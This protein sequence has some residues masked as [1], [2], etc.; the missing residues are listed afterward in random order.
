M[1]LVALPV[2][3]LAFRFLRHTR[4]GRS[5][6]LP[7]YDPPPDVTY[8]D[9][10]VIGY[11]HT[12]RGKQ[13]GE[14][15]DGMDDDDAWE[16]NDYGMLTALGSFGNVQCTGVPGSGKSTGFIDPYLDQAIAK[17][18]KPCRPDQ[19]SLGGDGR[20][21][22]T[23]TPAWTV[24]V[25]TY[26]RT[27]MQYLA[28]LFGVRVGQFETR[29]EVRHRPAPYAG[30]TPTEAEAEYDRLLALHLEKR[31]SIFFLDYKGD[32]TDRIRRMAILHGREMDVRI[33][34]PGGEY[35]HNVLHPLADAGRQAAAF[36]EAHHAVKREPGHPFWND[37]MY[38]WL[39]HAIRLL[40]AVAPGDLRI[41]MLKQMIEDPKT[42]EQ[43]LTKAKERYSQ[44]ARD[45]HQ[46]EARGDTQV[47]PGIHVVDLKSAIDFLSHFDKLDKRHRDQVL[48]GV[49]AHCELFQQ[50]RI[51]EIFAPQMPPIF[52]GFEAM[53]EQ[54]LIVGVRVPVGDY[55]Q[56]ATAIGIHLLAEAQYAVLRRRERADFTAGSRVVAF[57]IDEMAHYLN[58]LTTASLSQNRQS[59][60]IF[61][62]A[63]QTQ[64][65][66][67]A[68][69]IAVGREF[70]NQTQT[71]I[72]F[73]APHGVA[74]Q[75]ESEIFGTRR[76]YVGKFDNATGV[77]S[78]GRHTITEHTRFEETERAWFDAA[79]FEQL[80][81]FECL[82][83]VFD[84]IEGHPP[85]KLY[86][87]PYYE[88]PNG[89]AISAVSLPVHREPH[90]LTLL[91]GEYAS[92]DRIL[93]AIL[94]QGGFVIVESL[95][96]R[97]GTL[98][99]FKFVNAAGTVIAAREAVDRCAQVIAQLFGNPA[100]HRTLVFTAMATGAT[101]FTHA[102]GGGFGQMIDLAEV[103]R[104][105]DTLLDNSHGLASTSDYCA[106]FA[107]I[108][109]RPLPYSVLGG[110]EYHRDLPT[111]QDQIIRDSRTLIEIYQQAMR[112]VTAEGRATLQQ[113][114]R[115]A[116]ETLSRLLN[117]S[118]AGTVSTP[119]PTP[120]PP[121]S[122]VQSPNAGAPLEETPTDASDA[123]TPTPAEPTAA[124]SQPPRRRGRRRSRGSRHTGPDWSD[125]GDVP[126]TPPDQS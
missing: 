8:N 38:Q 61:V 106:L 34:E 6:I 35:T 15:F 43:L 26:L 36:L 89:R 60:A 107:A 14:Q 72:A 50:A 45:Q 10:I 22:G 52:S 103:L 126:P 105:S 102:Y 57:V 25:G 95:L 115:S 110:W 11:G 122:S 28:C 46:A 20:Y 80:Q 77:D 71:K 104:E 109:R 75:R 63:H 9:D 41:P 86:T 82:V 53:I 24:R 116:Q 83:K 117:G 7:P 2:M 120:A 30:M 96:D 66:V 48:V 118:T 90:P 123:T 74:A 87:T 91:R 81:V 44:M 21:A 100:E 32:Q 97:A 69:A 54:G 93:K 19:E 31:W 84:G 39:T 64:D 33:L 114:Y 29:P 56:L 121:Q 23:P 70:I 111:H 37:V 40:Q 98:A 49:N 76:V 78:I 88:S 65:Q 119:T 99:G 125:P 73:R 4:D 124:D 42:V 67:D 27:R 58:H 47:G 16:T 5:V 12:R 59:R 62:A 94:G 68:F 13:P 79:D 92:D 108:A 1:L 51:A 112:T 101:Y 3:Y 18:P 17:W 113:Y 85:R 55:G